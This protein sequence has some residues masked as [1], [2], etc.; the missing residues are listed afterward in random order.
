MKTTLLSTLAAGLAVTFVTPLTAASGELLAEWNNFSQLTAETPLA[1][2]AGSKTDWTFTLG[3]GSVN[4][5]GSLQTGIGRAPAVNFANETLNVGY[6]GQQKMTIVVTL[7]GA[8]ATPVINK[9]LLH[10]GNGG[11]GIGVAL[12]AYDA[13]LKTASL[14]G[15]WGNRA[16]GNCTTFPALNDLTDSTKT[17]TLV[18]RTGSQ[19]SAVVQL[20]PDAKP[21]WTA[22]T[23]LQGGIINATQI[24]F[25]NF[26]NDATEGMNYIL[27]SVKIFDGVEADTV[28]HYTWK[29]TSTIFHK[30]PWQATSPL[31]VYEHTDW[32]IFAS[33]QTAYQ[34]PGAVLR[35]DAAAASGKGGLQAQFEPFDLFGLIVEQGATGYSFAK[36][37]NNRPTDFGDKKNHEQHG[38]MILHEN[39]TV[40]RGGKTTFHGPLSISIDAGKMLQVNNDSQIAKGT[41]VTLD[42]KGTFFVAD[43]SILGTLINKGTLKVSGS[44]TVN[45]PAKDTTLGGTIEG[46]GKLIKQGTGILR[47]TGKNTFSGGL[48]IQG[49]TVVE[50]GLREQS[51]ALGTG[52][53]ANRWASKVTLKRGVFDLN[54][55]GNYKNSSETGIDEQY[56]GWLSVQTLTLGGMAG[57]SEVC[58]G[59]FGIGVENAIV[60]DTHNNPDT[61]TI[62]AA[63]DLTGTSTECTRTFNIGDS[64]ATDVEIDFTGGMHANGGIDGQKTTITKDGPGTMR[65]SCNFGFPGLTVSAGKLVIGKDMPF[66]QETFQTLTVAKGA[67]LDL[68]GHQVSVA[69][70]AGDGTIVGAAQG[71]LKVT[72]TNSFAGNNY[73]LPAGEASAGL[74][75]PQQ[76]V[77]SQALATAMQAANLP[78]TAATA[79][80]VRLA[81]GAKPGASAAETAANALSLFKGLTVTAEEKASA[82]TMAAGSEPKTVVLTVDYSFGLTYLRAMPTENGQLALTAKACV[83]TAGGTGATFVPGTRVALFR[84]G[85]IEPLAVTAVGEAGLSEVTFNKE[86]AADAPIARFYV[87]ALEAEGPVQP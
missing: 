68:N 51:G 47:L 11:S 85:S 6:S 46:T 53:D 10:C 58:N 83:E 1:P 41:E 23:G 52:K 77:L 13:S 60:Y 39:F 61:A 29:G 17:L 73:L 18:F 45:S 55:A 8:P 14:T 30:G 69:N 72:G 48:E 15:I 34:A 28:K 4:E 33:N 59:R 80:E 64:S 26:V 22:F 44:L 49:G 37:G 2:Q 81:G 3:G 70:L 86:I 87:K 84:E 74:T 27:K 24:T 42:G 36:A 57:T 35:L 62:S 31:H 75:G 25:G 82:Q 78:A 76:S 40:A 54:N 56:R 20:M 66:V 63:Y 50:S 21:E 19:P 7:K 71:A 9:P 43:H 65:L 67:V 79:L 32:T 16:W 12:H 5:D 38:H